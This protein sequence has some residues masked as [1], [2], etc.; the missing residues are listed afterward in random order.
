MSGV[1][2]LV[3]TRKG[4]F[5]LT[6]DA[7]REQWDITGPH[8]GGWEMFHL[9]GSPAEPNRVYASLSGGRDGQL[10]QRSSDGGKTWEAVGNQF[11]YNGVLGTH[12]WYDGTL[13]PWEF[14][15]VWHLEPS[16]TDPDTVFAGGEDA[17][18]FRSTDGGQTWHEFAGLRGQCSAP[19][20]QP[21]NGG[22]CLHTILLN[23]SKPRR[24]AL[25]IACHRDDVNGLWLVRV[26]IDDEAEVAGQIAADLLP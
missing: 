2:V 6:S 14:K 23:P 13:R 15:R 20:W 8:F 9:K 24:M 21:G 4:A 19:S 22:L 26:N 16:L 17:A 11:M 7:R 10:I 5:L 18:V 12:Q 25:P 1:R 3:G